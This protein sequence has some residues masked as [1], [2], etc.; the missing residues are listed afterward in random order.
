MPAPVKPI[1]LLACIFC[2]ILIPFVLSDD[3]PPRAA[4]PEKKQAPAK[5]GS[6]A[7]AIL[8]IMAISAI[9]YCSL[10]IHAQARTK[11]SLPCLPRT[12]VW[13][14][15]HD[16]AKMKEHILQSG[17]DIGVLTTKIREGDIAAA[18]KLVYQDT[19]YMGTLWDH[20]LTMWNGDKVVK[21][22][23]GY[24]DPYIRLLQSVCEAVFLIN[25]ADGANGSNAQAYIDYQRCIAVDYNVILKAAIG[26]FNNDLFKQGS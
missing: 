13:T 6:L 14:L 11:E 26:T 18:L 1:G 17:I 5:E 3:T 23:T 25:G 10:T 8:T 19:I 4:I 21:F 12:N 9:V 20:R 22:S 24:R 16:S 15:I 7:Q 2:P